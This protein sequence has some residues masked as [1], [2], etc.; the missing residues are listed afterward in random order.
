MPDQSRSRRL[1]WFV[2][3]WCASVAVVGTVS[4]ILRTWLLD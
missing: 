1:V 4:L 3:L 2:A